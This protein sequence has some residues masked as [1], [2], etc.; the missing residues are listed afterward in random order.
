MALAARVNRSRACCASGLQSDDYL[1]SSRL[2]I[3]LAG[4]FRPAGHGGNRPAAEAV[5]VAKA[6]GGLC[7]YLATVRTVAIAARRVPT[8]VRQ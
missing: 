2:Q 4:P 6:Q 3:M 1:A 7:W 8:G 5:R